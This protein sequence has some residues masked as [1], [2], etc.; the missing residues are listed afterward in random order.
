VIVSY[1]R[2]PAKI[3]KRVPIGLALTYATMFMSPAN[4]ATANRLAAQGLVTW[5]NYPEL[6]KPHGTYDN[7]SVSVDA[8]WVQL[9]GALAVDY[10]AKRAWDD[11]KGP[12]MAAAITRMI[13]RVVAG[14]ALRQSAKD[15]TVGAILSLGTQAAL[16]AAD[17]PDTRSWET[18]PA[19]VVVG[20]M[21]V[22]AGKHRIILTSRGQKRER[23][24]TLEPKGWA[25]AGITVLR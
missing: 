1:G 25:V 15:S 5:I 20:R 21:R 18:L 10:E 3:A 4:A 6:G 8:D 22:P 9:E 17:T 16:V 2:V 19:R 12:I 11:A 13:A 7:P 24:V 14:E 23:M